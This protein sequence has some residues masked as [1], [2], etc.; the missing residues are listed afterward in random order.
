MADGRFLSKSVGYDERLNNL[1]LMAHF[2][3]VQTI[4]HLDR[5]G[6][7]T[8]ERGAVK[9]MAVPA[10]SEFTLELVASC[11]EEW[12]AADL[13]LEYRSGRAG[14]ALYFYGFQK[15]QKNLR[16]NR[17]AGSRFDCP[18]GY[19]RTE[20]GLVLI[21]GNYSAITPAQLRQESDITPALLPHNSRT[22]PDEGKGR[23]EKGRE[24]NGMEEKRS[25]AQRGLGGGLGRA[26]HSEPEPGEEVDEDGDP[27]P[28]SAIVEI[29]TGVGMETATAEHIAG[30]WDLPTVKA[31]VERYR[32]DRESGKVR[33]PG[34]ILTRLKE[35]WPARAAPP[36]VTAED[37]SRHRR[38]KY[39]PEE[40]ADIIIH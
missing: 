38:N 15:N 8:A 25:Q 23:E 35:G 32:R 34:V 12:K 22:T 2:L 37:E 39:I 1:S 19:Q 6:I 26:G 5:D 31:Q 3:F 33:S 21:D 28:E 20:L 16:Y 18:P 17:E 4:P 36:E 29:L 24:E 27:E 11:V 13:V 10:R 9:A 30:Q 14:T 7:V 40:F